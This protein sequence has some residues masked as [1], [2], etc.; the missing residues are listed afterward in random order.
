MNCR[1]HRLALCFK[2]LRND[3]PWLETIDSVLL[4][5]WKAFHFSSKNR[6]IFNEIQEAYGLKTLSIIKAAITRCLS[7]GGAC[8]RCRERYCIILESLDDIITNNPRAELVGIRNQLLQTRYYHADL[9]SRRCLECDECF[10]IGFTVKP[11]RFSC[12]EKIC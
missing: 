11:Q 8:K 12:P 3:F 2:H 1:N 6:F 5:F 4:G 10:V 7:N 9:F